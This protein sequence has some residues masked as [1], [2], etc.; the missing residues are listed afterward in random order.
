M[1]ENK[2]PRRYYHF[3]RLHRIRATRK[4]MKMVRVSREFLESSGLG[5][6][7]Y[8]QEAGK[9]TPRTFARFMILSFSRKCLGYLG[10]GSERYF[11]VAGKRISRSFIRCLMLVAQVFSIIMFSVVTCVNAKNGLQEILFPLHL[12]FLAIM[13]MVVYIVLMKKS[14]RMAELGD[15]LRDVID[16][17]KCSSMKSLY[18][19]PD[20]CA[21]WIS[22]SSFQDVVNRASQ[23]SFMRNK[24]PTSWK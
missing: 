24:M 20:Y 19:V 12:I 22:I 5:H 14:A 18:I 2:L 1:K 10:L 17:R 21:V 8:I 3:I 9:Q 7:L 11:E 23:R 6:K 15:F 13:N 4:T 16:N